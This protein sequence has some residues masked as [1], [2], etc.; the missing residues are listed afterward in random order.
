MRFFLNILCEGQTEERFVNEILKPYFRGLDVCVKHRLITTNHKK[1]AQG[2]L[3]N[4]QRV[5]GDLEKWMHELSFHRDE[6]HC[7]T[8]MFDFYALPTDFPS[9][10]LEMQ[11]PYQKVNALEDAFGK[12]INAQHFIPYIQL[13][14]FEA[15]LFADLDKLAIYYEKNVEELKKS[16][17]VAK[18]NPELVNSKAAPSKRIIGV[19]GRYKKSDGV[20][21]LKEI[22]LTTLRSRCQH[23]DEWLQK[24]EME[25][26]GEGSALGCVTQ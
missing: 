5:K 17:S 8:T 16:L 20:E 4:Y 23:F 15:L 21:I 24:I 13:H 11:N 18:N 10:W 14:E 26:G 2:G 1:K 25:L 6:R 7:F 12:N 9:Y 19:L 3:G 22:G